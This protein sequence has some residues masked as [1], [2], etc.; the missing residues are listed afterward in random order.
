VKCENDLDL[1]VKEM[2]F[3]IEDAA[4]E[5]VFDGLDKEIVEY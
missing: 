2:G 5:L 4:A 3:D 1:L